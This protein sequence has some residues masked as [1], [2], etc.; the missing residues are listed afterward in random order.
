[1]VAVLSIDD[2]GTECYDSPDGA[3]D[4]EGEEGVPMLSQSDDSADK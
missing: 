4:E 3:P 1:L 2:P